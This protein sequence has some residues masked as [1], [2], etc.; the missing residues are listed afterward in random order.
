M[1]LFSSSLTGGH[2]MI[3]TSF[4]D[5]RSSKQRICAILVAYEGSISV[6][7]FTVSSLS[8]LMARL[9]CLTRRKAQFLIASMPVWSD[10]DASFR[11]MLQTCNMRG[12][13]TTPKGRLSIDTSLGLVICPPG[14]KGLHSP[15]Y[16]DREFS[17]SSL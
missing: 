3:K 1:T 9:P 13:I 8:D 17:M 10:A 15:H 5:S 11:S 12:G 7:L 16:V 6:R 2:S 4:E 14:G